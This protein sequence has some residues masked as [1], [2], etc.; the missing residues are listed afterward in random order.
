MPFFQN[1]IFLNMRRHFGKCHSVKKKNKVSSD[2]YKPIAICSALWLFSLN[3]IIK[4]V[5]NANTTKWA[6]H[7]KKIKIEGPILGLMVET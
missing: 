5:C 3:Q 4:K 7:D 1:P 2:R 6:Q